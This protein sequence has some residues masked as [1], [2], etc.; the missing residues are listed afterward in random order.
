M[1]LHERMTNEGQRLVKKRGLGKVEESFK[2]GRG[3][4]G[5]IEKI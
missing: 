3:R 2:K 4:G 5:E 1:E